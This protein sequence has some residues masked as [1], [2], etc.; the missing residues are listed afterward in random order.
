MRGGRPRLFSC[1]L[2]G[3][4]YRQVAAL[5]CSAVLPQIDPLPDAERTLSVT[6]RQGQV[7]SG[8][9]GPDVGRHII[10]S[11]IGVI[12]YRVTVCNQP[13]HIAVKVAANIRI[14]ILAHYQRGTGVLQ[15]YM[16]Q[17]GGDSGQ[18][19]LFPYGCGDGCGAAS[20]CCE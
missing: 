10:G 12:E 3:H 2:A 11:F 15:E 5:A 4:R 6:D 16:A 17:A 14:C 8:Q 7:V 9:Y 19:H 18:V 13:R 20:A 1:L